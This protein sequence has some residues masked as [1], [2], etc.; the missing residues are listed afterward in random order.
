LAQQHAGPVASL[1]AARAGLDV[2]EAVQRIGRVA[3]H[4][5]EFELFDFNGHFGGFAFDGYQAGFIVV[6]FLHVEQLGVVGELTGQAIEHDH[7]IFQ[8][9]FLAAQIL[10][11]LG[12]IPDGGVFQRGFDFF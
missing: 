5:A 2:Q 7:D 11:P 9:F 4:A 10:R 1:G 8:R 12:V 6:G 3:E